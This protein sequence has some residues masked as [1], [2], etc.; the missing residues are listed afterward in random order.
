MTHRNRLRAALLVALAALAAC[1]ARD[2][3]ESEGV[4]PVA[5]SAPRF[6]DADPTD[7]PGR[8]PAS[9]PIHGIDISRWQGVVDWPTARANGVGC[10]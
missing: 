9:Y 6:G 5:V 2:R 1:G 10:A 4:R 7:W 8:G 3:A